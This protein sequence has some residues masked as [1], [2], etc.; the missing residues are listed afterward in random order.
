M[1]IEQRADG[2]YQKVLTDVEFRLLRALAIE[3][4]NRRNQIEALE[5]RIKALEKEITSLKTRVQALEVR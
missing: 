3:K 1:R 5:N 2:T 4:T